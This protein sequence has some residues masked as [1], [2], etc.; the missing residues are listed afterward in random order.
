MIK[1]KNGTTEVLSLVS[2]LLKQ[3]NENGEYDA[4]LEIINK[5]VEKKSIKSKGMAKRPLTEDEYIK[6]I[7]TLK[8]GTT[9]TKDGIT[10]T[11]LPNYQVALA[12]VIEATTGLRI[13]DVL[14]LKVS[15]FLKEKL[16]I[17]EKKTNKLQYRKINSQLIAQVNKYAISNRL[18]EDDY[19]INCSE[20]NVQRYLKFAVESLNYE[21]IGTHSFRK[22]Y[23]QYVYNQT[24]D[25]RIVQALLNHS[26]TDTTERYLGINYEEID[27]ISGAVDFTNVLNN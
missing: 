5:P 19:V 23:A 20:R 16:E 15:D 1:D 6:I 2:E 26:S 14:K 21:N 3:L 9:Y 24:K 17:R 12:L 11:I 7:T 27:R 18:G 25:I 22:Y 4:A 8:E 10:K 13:S